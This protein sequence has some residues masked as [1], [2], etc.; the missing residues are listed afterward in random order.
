[1][2]D[3]SGWDA[4]D[5]DHGRPLVASSS[6]RQRKLARA[7]FDR[8]LA[9]RADKLRKQRQVRAA[10]AGLVAVTLVILG[11]FWLGGAFDSKPEPVTPAAD[12]TWNGQNIAAND[13]FT[14]EGT[15]PTDV[16][17]FGTATMTLA[18]GTGN[19]TGSLNRTLAQCG[20]ASIEY[21]ASKGY[22]NGTKCFEL[23]T[24]DGHYALRCGD[25]SETGVGGASYTY[26]LENA[27]HA[28]DPNA[29]P[30][31]APSASPSTFVRYKRGDI[32]VDSSKSGSQFL[33]FTKDS[34]TPANYSIIGS[35]TS[36]LDILDKIVEAGVTMSAANVETKPKQ[37][38]V[39]QTLTVTPDA[40]PAS[41]APSATP[42]PSASTAN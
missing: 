33:I 41:P 26:P 14:D 1:M 12:C 35:V 37:D 21:L 27:P 34:T 29:S 5:G 42:S 10:V 28:S 39:I 17:N 20:I 30:S 38:V 19:I 4:V 25:K 31:P 16:T 13:K 22:F 9:R 7:K 11:G 40:T 3:T 2:G 36:G 18:L 8:Q 6:T 23:T 24:T 15:P 32:V